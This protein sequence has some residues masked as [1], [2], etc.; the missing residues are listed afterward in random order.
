GDPRP[1]EI[2]SERS[3]FE[4][5]A[6]RRTRDCRK[7][8]RRGNRLRGRTYRV[9]RLQHAASRTTA[10]HLSIAVQLHL[11]GRT[12]RGSL[13]LVKTSWK[14]EMALPLP[15]DHREAPA[16]ALFGSVLRRGLTRVATIATRT[17]TRNAEF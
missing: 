12:T 6:R 2:R 17:A 10:R 1:G 13:T 14:L 7:G 3:A 4:R 8:G 15:H 5:L 9:A 16:D 11:H